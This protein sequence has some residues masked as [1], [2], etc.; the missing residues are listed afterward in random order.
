LARGVAAAFV[1]AAGL[2]LSIPETGV[3]MYQLLVVGTGDQLWSGTIGIT[4][5]FY[6]SAVA[7]CR[8]LRNV[9]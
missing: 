6:T 1:F 9:A 3:N 8:G 7:S 5:D 2:D 4:P